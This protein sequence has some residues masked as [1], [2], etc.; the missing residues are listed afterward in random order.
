MKKLIFIFSLLVLYSCSS[1]TTTEEEE[2]ATQS[3]EDRVV[4]MEFNTTEPN[5]DEVRVN[6]FD[7]T[8][9][10]YPILIH[11]FEYN[12]AGE[13]IPYI[14]TFENYNF[15]YIN[16]TAYRNNP[17]TAEISVKIY[18]DDELVVEETGKGENGEYAEVAFN[19]DAGF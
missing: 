4:R 15:R 9:N 3:A 8:T 11:Q 13:A 7:Y 1:A 2:T 6:Y 16:G 18:V 19:Y 17:S 10:T 5:F 12:S 14:V